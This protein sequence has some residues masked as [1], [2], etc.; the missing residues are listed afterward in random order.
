MR[1]LI[2]HKDGESSVV[3]WIKKRIDN[4]LNFLAITEGATGSGKSWSNL[5]ICYELDSEFNPEEQ[6]AFNFKKLMQIINR[7]NSKDDPLHK[8]KYKV[9]LFDE[10]QTQVNKREW[11]S[12]VNK[13]FL[14]LTSTFRHQNIIVLFTSPY[15][16]FIDSATMK[17]IHVKFEVRG[18]NKKT[19]LTHLRPKILQYNSRLRKFYE[20]SLYVIRDGKANKLS[21]WFVPKPPKHLILPYEDMKTEFTTQLNKEITEELEAMENNKQ[22]T[23]IS[24]SFDTRK[25]LTEHQKEVMELLAKYKPIEVSKIMNINQGTISLIKKRARLKGYSPEEFKNV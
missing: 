22:K 14:Y 6:I 1:N 9:I 19:E 16:D 8:R 18:W 10:A 3:R 15:S 17:L 20:H 25:P 21:D 5:T 2:M 11:Q 24:P 7:F 12:R 4:N 13:L 23:V